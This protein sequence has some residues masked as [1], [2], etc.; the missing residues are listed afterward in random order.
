MT[1]SELQRAIDEHQAF[2]DEQT[3]TTPEVLKRKK[4]LAVLRAAQEK[5]GKQAATARAPGARGRRKGK[6]KRTMP[7]RPRSLD[8]G[9]LHLAAMTPDA[10]RTE[11]D[12][13]VAYLA[14]GPPKAERKVLEYELPFLEE[15]VG[16]ARA[17]ELGEK[18]RERFEQA[19]TP[20][21]GDEADQL[22]E[23]LRRVQNATPDPSQEDIWLI[24]YDDRVF[25]LTGAEL[26]QVQ[27]TMVGGLIRAPAPSRTRS[28][29]AIA[30]LSALHT[31]NEVKAAPGNQLAGYDT[32]HPLY[33]AR[34]M[35][36]Y[37]IPTRPDARRRSE[38]LLS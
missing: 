35:L 16:V 37:L 20:T 28:Q 1:W 23:A 22:M 21:K 18:H 3:A 4:R 25:P 24:H 26:M 2:I 6:G 33:V 8:E 9:S 11:L 27:E 5:L 17:Q 36:F 14:A 13:V 31:H 34:A 32:S 30:Y 29:Y 10:V 15:A 7:P 19:V 12:L 38:R